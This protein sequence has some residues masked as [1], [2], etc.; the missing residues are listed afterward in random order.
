MPFEDCWVSCYWHD[1]LLL[2]LSIYVYAFKLAGP[3]KT[4]KQGRALLRN[5]LVI[6]PEARM[7]DKSLA[8]L[9]CKTGV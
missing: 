9:G 8:Y 1:E 4:I 2:F 6:E 5:S 3:E 7:E